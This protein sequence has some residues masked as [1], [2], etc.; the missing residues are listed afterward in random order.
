MF[1]VFGFGFLSAAGNSPDD[2]GPVR[3]NLLRKK[4]AS[5]P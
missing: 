4:G 3:I 1:V 2:Q 5:A